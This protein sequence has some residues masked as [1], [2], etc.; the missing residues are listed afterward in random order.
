MN[1][2]DWMS[3]ARRTDALVIAVIGLIALAARLAVVGGVP[4]SAPVSDMQ[5][6]WERAVYIAHHGQL[7]PNSWRM[8]GYPTALAVIFAAASGPSLAVT[9]VFNVVAGVAAPLLTYWRARRRLDVWSA[10]FAGLAVAV[11]PSFLIYSTF[12]ATER[13]SPYLFSVR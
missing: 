4:V 2:N 11:Y 12:V 10:M 7:Y 9:R 5:E 8:P 1:E 13:S 3:T 6:Y